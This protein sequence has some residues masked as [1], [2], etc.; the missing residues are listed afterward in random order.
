MTTQEMLRAVERERGA[1]VEWWWAPHAR[2]P[3]GVVGQLW[4]G[5]P[6]QLPVG[7]HF[8]AP[9]AHQELMIAWTLIVQHLHRTTFPTGL[10]A[11]HLRDFAPERWRR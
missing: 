7:V 6:W 10:P 9:P 1:L 11:M 5:A 2:H 8:K 3:D 4:A